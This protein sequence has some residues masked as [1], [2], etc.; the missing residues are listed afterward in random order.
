[1]ALRLLVTSGGSFGAS[2]LEQEIG[3]GQ[4]SRI[5][6]VEVHWPTSGTTQV[7]DDVPLDTRIEVTEGDDAY[8]VAARPSFKLAPFRRSEDTR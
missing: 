6:R 7:F 8:T 3:L 2:S 4:A 5:V 1:M